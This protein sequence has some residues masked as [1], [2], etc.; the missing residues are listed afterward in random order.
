MK[1]LA[2]WFLLGFVVYGQPKR[3]VE[4]FATGAGAVRITPIRHA[5]LLIQAGG[6]AIYVD[7][8]QGDY[9][10]L[11]PADLIL[12]TDIHPDHM[13]ASRIAQLRQPSTA[14]IAPAAVAKTVTEAAVIRIGETKEFGKWRIEAIAAYNI[15]SQPGAQVYHEK[16][17]GVGYVLSYGGKRF[18]FSGDT[19]NIPEMRALKN[20]D[21]A[22][23]CMNLP[24]TMPPEEAAQA[25]RA[26][27]PAIVYPYHYH[28]SDLKVF[29]KALEGSGVEV[30]IRDWYY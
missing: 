24:Y 15:P 7:P 17:R 20:I 1:A 10:G 3:S 30:R 22:F 6:Q 5:S 4:E 18:Y 9:T 8:S 14:I 2:C 12:I 19:E 13:D 21:V 25:V 26:F 27:K 16:G 11:P 23:V 29:E 28:G